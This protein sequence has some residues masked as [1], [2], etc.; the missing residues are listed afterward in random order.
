MIDNIFERVKCYRTISWLCKN[1][2]RFGILEDSLCGTWSLEWDLI[3]AGLLLYMMEM[4]DLTDLGTVKLDFTSISHPVDGYDSSIAVDCGIPYVVI[5]KL[6][7]DVDCSLFSVMDVPECF[8]EL[9]GS[10]AH[11]IHDLTVECFIID[12]IKGIF[13]LDLLSSNLVKFPLKKLS[14]TLL[15]NGPHNRDRHDYSFLLE[16]IESL[17]SLETLHLFIPDYICSIQSKSLQTLEFST[18][19][20]LVKCLCPALE[21][22]TL[23][24]KNPGTSQLLSDCTH[25]IRQLTLDYCY[26]FDD[27]PIDVTDT[28]LTEIIQG[29][30]LLEKL[31][32][33]GGS[34]DGD[35]YLDIKSNSL[36]EINLKDCEN[37][38]YV[39]SCICPNL[40]SLECMY[41][42][43]S[44][45]LC[46]LNHMEQLDVILAD[47]KKWENIIKFHECLFENSPRPFF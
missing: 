13:D 47:S 37:S 46:L 5:S 32:I 12:D 8:F 6:M 20:E 25:S 44:Y 38:F 14:L 15:I 43:Y 2:V 35:I 30:P 21:N 24:L 1:H 16:A 17:S 29:M 31:K 28:C 40:K 33:I 42:Q 34:S 4:C 11:K 22:L 18:S 7:D 27:D 3:D 36:Q 19:D 9:L 39:S 10:R 45:P 26:Y 23:A 41:S